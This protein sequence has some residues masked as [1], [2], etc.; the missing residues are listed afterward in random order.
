[1]N[2]AVGAMVGQTT[3][4]A[5]RSS[6][7]LV[8]LQL[9]WN[10]LELDHLTKTAPWR[11]ID[12]GRFKMVFAGRHREIGEVAI[13]RYKADDNRNE[14]RILRMLSNP[15]GS[16]Y[17]PE[18]YGVCMEPSGCLLLAQELSIVGSVKNALKEPKLVSMLSSNHKL[19]IAAQFAEAV[20]VLELKRIVHTDLACRNFLIYE[21]S[22]H[23]EQTIVKL[24]DFTS[25]ICLPSNVDHIVS[26]M[27]QA[28]RWCAPETVANNT[29][30]HK[31][32]VWSLGVSIWELFA[33]GAAPWANCKKR[34][35][36][37][38]KLRGL[39]EK[40]KSPDANVSDDFPAP[41][42]LDMYSS[43]ARTSML[44]CLLPS[45]A[46]RLSSSQ[47]VCAF[48]QIVQL[49]DTGETEDKKELPLRQVSAV[50][51]QDACA[52]Q[53]S[54]SSQYG[55]ASIGENS[56]FRAMRSGS[57]DLNEYVQGCL[58]SPIEKCD[59]DS[60][61]AQCGSDPGTPPTRSPS[62]EPLCLN[63]KELEV[64]TPSSSGSSS[65][66]GPVTHFEDISTAVPST[67]FQSETAVMMTSTPATA[68]TTPDLP[69]DGSKAQAGKLPQRMESL[70]NMRDF[71]AS[72]EAVCG[73]S[74]DALISMR[75]GLAA[76]Q[77]RAQ[78][79][80][81]AAAAPRQQYTQFSQEGYYAH[82][83]TAAPLAPQVVWAR[84]RVL[85]PSRHAV[86]GFCR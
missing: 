8:A 55:R 83:D 5:R 45:P 44:S 69:Q 54:N 33:D 79:A 32:D 23:P 62:P 20:S 43:V 37:A 3:G 13:L 39:A 36:V 52:R 49:P 34:A 80:F 50:A 25:S 60:P 51:V 38:E 67:P 12:K 86:H 64:S 48:R 29:W 63:E 74:L 82:R 42:D 2:F 61:S 70:K 22:Q 77:A 21:L 75:R 7:A 27:P 30:S 1:L 59:S 46:A 17:I 31:T 26:K 76:E 81:V 56:L 41:A 84:R 66:D 19:C 15:S 11:E 65:D 58:S 68:V 47:V 78:E 24:T 35:D 28:T 73:L 9:Q 6:T 16:N 71:L 57:V 72:P 18:V 4:N 85:S 40:Q 53:V 14:A 10:E